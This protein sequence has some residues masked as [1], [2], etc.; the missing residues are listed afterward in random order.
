[1]RRLLAVYVLLLTTLAVTPAAASTPVA[2]AHAHNDHE[3][4]R[5]PSDAL[6]QGCTSVEA[7]V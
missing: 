1:M 4:E 2:R 5:P 3:H 7:G 6:D